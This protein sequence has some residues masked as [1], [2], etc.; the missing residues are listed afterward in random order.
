[1]LIAQLDNVKLGPEAIDVWAKPNPR[2]FI[3]KSLKKPMIILSAWSSYCG[4]L[5]V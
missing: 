5:F 3:T 2:M 4:V 1:M